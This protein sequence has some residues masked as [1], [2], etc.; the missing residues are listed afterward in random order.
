M[1]ERAC[2]VV[3]VGAGPN[4]LAAAIE[5]ARHGLSVRVLEG[6]ERIGGGVRSAP[7]TLPGFLHD[8]CSAIHPMAVASPFFRSLPLERWGV[9]W[10]FPEA[11][12]AHPLDDGTAALAGQPLAATARTLGADARAYT[13][14]MQPLVDRAPELLEEVLRPLRVP[15]RWGLMAR[16]GALALR[17]CTGV[18]A[19]RFRDRQARAL[20]AGCCAHSIMPLDRAGTASFGLV[21]LATAHAVGWPCV[22]GGSQRITEALADCLKSLGGEVRTGQPVRSM[23]DLP[24][25]RAVLFDLAPRAIAKIADDELPSRYRRALSS[26]RHGPGVFKIDWALDGPIPW[27]AADCSRAATVHLGG[28]LE[29]LTA[30]ESAAWSGRHAEQPF[31]LLAQPSLFDPTRAPAGRHVGWAYCHVPSGSSFDMTERLERQ[32][33]RFA[34]GFRDLIL[35]RHTMNSPELEAYNP[36]L[37]GGDIG[38]GANTLRQLLARPQV[39]IDPYTTPNRRIFICSS[40]TPPGGGVHGMCG[41]WAARSALRRTFGIRA[42]AG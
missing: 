10:V 14:L 2:D 31:V 7:L 13:A 32:V 6:T 12:V 8:V 30:S 28:T 23:R 11:A 37:V 18:A 17:S 39:R 20:F 16:F 42:P 1:A 22:K 4:G 24:Q 5:L 19:G 27:K 21:L 38:G 15:G 41:Y 33:E 26:F 25:A 36:N 35:A 40:S 29:E 34:P 3:V 9:E